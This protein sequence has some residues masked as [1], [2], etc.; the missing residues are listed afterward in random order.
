MFGNDGDTVKDNNIDK[1]AGNGE[2]G[3]DSVDGDGNASP[4]TQ[5]F[6]AP[7]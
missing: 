7:P 5:P 4:P 1:D 2:D 6:E 3:N